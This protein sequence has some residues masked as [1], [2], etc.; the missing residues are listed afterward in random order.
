M[1]EGK[2]KV[3]IERELAEFLREHPTLTSLN[4]ARR[5]ALIN[6]KVSEQN[7]TSEQIAAR[8]L[9]DDREL[10]KLLL[11]GGSIDVGPIAAPATE[12]FKGRR[13]PTFFGLVRPKERHGHANT[14]VAKGSRILLEFQTDAEN[15]YFSRKETPGRWRVAELVTNEDVSHMFSD[16]GPSGGSWTCWSNSLSEQFEVGDEIR[17]RVEIDDDDPTRFDPFTTVIQVAIQSE[18]IEAGKE[19]GFAPTKTNRP[20]APEGHSGLAARVRWTDQLG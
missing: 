8:L 3:E 20:K 19:R 14:A 12:E 1:R 15:S 2:L 5:E 6:K 10:R 17:L 18:T 7:G 16:R 4:Q 9:R 11:E 13:F